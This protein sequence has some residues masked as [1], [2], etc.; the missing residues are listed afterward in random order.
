MKAGQI[1]ETPIEDE[2]IYKTWLRYANERDV[3]EGVLKEKFNDWFV[4]LYVLFVV[5]IKT[6][7]VYIYFISY[8]SKEEMYMNT[9]INESLVTANNEEKGA[10]MVEYALLVALIAIALMAAIQFLQTGVSSEFSQVGSALR[11]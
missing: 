2:P 10:T 9:D 5:D 11:Q 4:A 1:Y 3:L 8:L 6:E 7:F